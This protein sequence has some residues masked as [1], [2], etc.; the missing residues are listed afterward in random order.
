MPEKSRDEIR[1]DAKEYKERHQRAQF[2]RARTSRSASVPISR[3][4]EGGGKGKA[5]KQRAAS[6]GL[7]GALRAVDAF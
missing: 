5:M 6:M 7:R 2:E 3:A 1:T 4:S